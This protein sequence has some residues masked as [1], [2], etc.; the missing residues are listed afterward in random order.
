MRECRDTDESGHALRE[1]PVEFLSFFFA[2]S[3]DAFASAI[4]IT[5]K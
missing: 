5:S 3:G 1:D 4:G 2:Q